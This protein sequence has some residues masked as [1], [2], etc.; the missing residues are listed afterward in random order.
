MRTFIK[1]LT[2][3]LTGIVVIVVCAVLLQFDGAPFILPLSFVA[4]PGSAILSY[5]LISKLLSPFVP[6]ESPSSVV[7]NDPVLV[8]PSASV[9]AG[10]EAAPTPAPVS[11]DLPPQRTPAYLVCW[12]SWH[13]VELYI[14]EVDS[15]ID[16]KQHMQLWSACFYAITKAISDQ[17]F[18]DEAYSHFATFAIRRVYDPRNRAYV[19]DEMRNDYRAMRPLLNSCRIMPC[20]E[21]GAG[22]LWQLLAPII[23]PDSAPPVQAEAFFVSNLMKAQKLALQQYRIASK[24]APT[25]RYSV[26]AS[27]KICT[28]PEESE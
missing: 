5:T 15:H 8:E 16:R 2:A 7:S 3:F 22:Q 17:R 12:F 10:P 28:L 9:S 21:E 13:F 27:P 20:D 24:G 4:I 19:V 23:Y 25:I 1:F 6:D 18:I 14:K 11:S 26:S